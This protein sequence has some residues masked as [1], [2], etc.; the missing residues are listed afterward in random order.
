MVWYNLLDFLTPKDF[1]HTENTSLAAEG[2]PEIDLN[3]P[4][5][6]VSYAII[7]MRRILQGFRKR[8]VG[9]YILSS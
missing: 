9:I 7:L 3:M 5:M 2:G 4:E 8:R 6:T 1:P